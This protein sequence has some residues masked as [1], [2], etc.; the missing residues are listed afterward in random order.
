MVINK[1]GMS[2]P[3][4]RQAIPRANTEI[5]PLP[6]KFYGINNY[7]DCMIAMNGCRDKAMQSYQRSGDATQ[8]HFAQMFHNAGHQDRLVRVN[9]G[10][11]QATAPQNE[12]EYHGACKLLLSDCG[13]NSLW[14]VARE[15]VVTDLQRFHSGQ[16]PESR[17]DMPTMS[18]VQNNDGSY[19]CSGNTFTRSLGLH[20]MQANHNAQACK[21]DMN[22]YQ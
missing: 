20:L 15:R 9:V 4:P 10:R 5:C 1:T 6:H 2:Y 3:Y 16:A 17:P 8:A 13:R 18:C 19:A 12:W 7:T 14:P 11:N 22:W 21:V